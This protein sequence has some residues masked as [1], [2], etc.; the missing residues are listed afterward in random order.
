MK[1]AALALAV[2][3]L[4]VV[5]GGATSFGAVGSVAAPA[6]NPDLA[7]AEALLKEGNIAP[8]L[9]IAQEIAVSPVADRDQGLAALE[10]M[11]QCYEQSKEYEKELNCYQQIGAMDWLR[12]FSKE[13]RKRM[14]DR[15]EAIAQR[16]EKGT[17]LTPRQIVRFSRIII[18]LRKPL[19]FDELLGG[20]ASLCEFRMLEA[21]ARAYDALGE[22]QLARADRFAA[23]ATPAP[24]ILLRRCQ[25][26]LALVSAMEKDGDSE[27]TEARLFSVLL[28]TPDD[29]TAFVCQAALTHAATRSA[30][31]TGSGQAG[32]GQAQRGDG[33]LAQ[34]RLK[35][36]FYLCP[37]RD[38]ALDILAEEAGLLAQRK[39]KSS[40][41]PETSLLLAQFVG[42]RPVEPRTGGKW[43]VASL[44]FPVQSLAGELPQAE[45]AS[46]RGKLDALKGQDPGTLRRRVRLLLLLGDP[47]T[48]SGQA[49]N[50][51][52]SQAHA[53]YAA[54]PSGL[55]VQIDAVR[56][57]IAA[58]KARNG[59]FLDPKPFLTFAAF[60][61]AGRDGRPGTE[62]DLPDPFA[63][64]LLRR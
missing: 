64:T 7:R 20:G 32:S 15:I 53:A 38:D 51:A 25:A 13:R 1:L 24:A 54:A 35:R 48:G 8:A 52:L 16:V 60:G 4:A 36:L 59:C 21:R 34:A 45:T 61:A 42:R 12:R 6:G 57:F 33:G 39:E 44:V 58:A 17:E 10:L 18:G 27:S 49:A 56:D 2:L 41:A 14:L 22:R 9:A 28:D 47:S 19:L 43:D 46:I 50:A 3:A 62:D 63:A 40:V 31:S 29:D 37:P 5:A 26:S 23:L 11:A 55:N 30:H